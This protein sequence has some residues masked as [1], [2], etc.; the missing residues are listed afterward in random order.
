MKHLTPIMTLVSKWYLE[1]DPVQGRLIDAEAQQ[2][3]HVWYDHATDHVRRGKKKWHS[4]PDALKDVLHALATL[5]EPG[6]NG[7]AAVCL[8]VGGV[9]QLCVNPP[10]LAALCQE[11]VCRQLWEACLHK[12]RLCAAIFN[13]RSDM[14]KKLPTVDRM[15][16]RWQTTG[17]K[18]A[19][20]AVLCGT[21][22]AAYLQAHLRPTMTTVFCRPEQA[23]LWRFH[24]FGDVRPHSHAADH[25]AMGSVVVLDDADWLVTQSGLAEAPL[26]QSVG[27]V[28][29]TCLASSTPPF[30]MWPCFA[31]WAQ[32]PA[33]GNHSEWIREAWRAARPRALHGQS[34]QR[35]IVSP[36][37]ELS[38]WVE[39]KHRLLPQCFTQHL[40]LHPDHPEVCSIC[41]HSAVDVLLGACGHSCCLACFQHCIKRDAR[42]MFCRSAIVS[43]TFYNTVVA[44][45]DARVAQDSSVVFVAPASGALPRCFVEWVNRQRGPGMVV[46]DIWEAR[47]ALRTY[48]G[49]TTWAIAGDDIP[50]WLDDL[51][52]GDFV[53]GD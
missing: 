44:W 21:G 32:L 7:D 51:L 50:A 19:S 52:Q 16:W 41:M 15:W 27:K 11:Y 14:P 23:W 8:L 45:A 3:Q 10:L 29:L 48:P 5:E 4:C 46:S 22:A 31:A 53:G 2:I 40:C 18:S 47:A 39:T 42:C 13:Y 28:W 26:P 49:I 1:R 37:F 12:A 33:H 30:Q 24:G 6:K 43:P 38:Q 34:P 25:T 35:I 36:K 9:I 20:P 17:A